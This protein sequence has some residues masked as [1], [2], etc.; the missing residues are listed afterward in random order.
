MLKTGDVAAELGVSRQHVVDLCDRGALPSTRVGSHRRIRRSD[1]EALLA[2]QT[3]THDQRKQLWM[4]RAML[5]HLLTRPEEV[6]ELARGNIAGWSTKHRADG[7]TVKYLREWEDILNQG[8][9]AVVETVLSASPRACE[10][11]QNSPFAGV[12]DQ[13]ERARALRTFRTVHP[14]S[15]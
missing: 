11:R 15:A 12:L 7:R 6:I 10:L 2:P 4:H 14:A 1:L 13:T 9:E 8:I 5:T 3:L